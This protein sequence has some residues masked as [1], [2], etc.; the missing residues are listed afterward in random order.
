MSP[1]WTVYVRFKD[2]KRSDSMDYRHE[3][4]RCQIRFG[5]QLLT[6]S[7]QVLWLVRCIIEFHKDSSSPKKIEGEQEWPLLPGFSYAQR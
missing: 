5:D 4:D 1:R 3:W 6:L 7:I 2:A